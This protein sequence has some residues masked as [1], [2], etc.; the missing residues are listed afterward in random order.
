MRSASLLSKN[1]WL[2][3]WNDFG[4]RHTSHVGIVS[5]LLKIYNFFSRPCSPTTMVF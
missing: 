4:V 5:K 3:G 1:G 2:A